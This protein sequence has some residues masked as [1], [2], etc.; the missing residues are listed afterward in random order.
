M[1]ILFLLKILLKDILKDKI[2]A[3]PMGL[4]IVILC[5]M[6]GKLRKKDWAVLR[7]PLSFILNN[8]SIGEYGRLTYAYKCCFKLT[9]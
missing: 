3:I 6:L 4:L 8:N 2:L 9:N 7:K 1:E 5:W